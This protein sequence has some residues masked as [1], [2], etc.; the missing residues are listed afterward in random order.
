MPSILVRYF[1]RRWGIQILAGFV[2]FGC[3]LIA[4]EVKG[5]SETIFE[6]HASIRKLIPLLLTT[7]PWNVG[8]IL[9]MTTVLGALMG[10][11]HLSEGSELVASQGLGHGTRGFLKPWGLLSLI[12]IV[13]SIVN[14]HW[15]YP[16]ASRMESRLFYEMVEETALTGGYM[17][18][19]GEEPKPIK[20]NA[21][22]HGSGDG[23]SALLQNQTV[24]WGVSKDDDKLHIIQMGPETVSHLISDTY[25]YKIE[26]VK[27]DRQSVIEQ[28]RLCFRFDD[29]KGKSVGRGAKANEHFMDMSYQ[30]FEVSQPV[31]IKK[32][33]LYVPTT[34]RHLNTG[35]LLRLA[36]SDHKDRIVAGIELFRRLSNPFACCA[37]LLLGIAIGL[38]HPR[39]YRGG[40]L[41]KSIL[42]IVV[43]IIALRVVEGWIENEAISWLGASAL[44]PSLFFVAGWLLL[45]RKMHPT[46]HGRGKVAVLLSEFLKR[47]GFHELLSQLKR[48]ARHILP[49]SIRTVFR[50]RHHGRRENKIITRWTA[51]KWWSNFWGVM[52]IF[53]LFHVFIEFS[54]LLS[55]IAM[56]GGRLWVFVK[57][58]V[59]NLPVALPF[60]L[61]IV[62]LFAWTLT[63]SNAAVSREWTALRAG[64]VSLVR[65]VM[66]SWK[67]WGT[68][69]IATFFV[70]AYLAPRTYA[71]KNRYYWQIKDKNSR[72]EK[73]AAPQAAEEFPTTLFMGNTGVFWYSE[74]SGRWG[75]PLLSPS[76]APSIIHW[77]YAD[78]L[79]QQADWDGT[80]WVQGVDAEALFP[81]S[82]LRK[83]RKVDEIP[84]SDLF[85]WQAWAP[86]PD[87]G[88]RLWGRLLKWLAGPCLF[89][90]A[91]G[92]LFP[93]PR[94]GR[95]LTLGYALVLSL[96]FIWMQTVFDGAAEAGHLPPLW[97]V[98]A[99]ILMLLGFGLVNLHRLRT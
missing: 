94:S 96:A 10:T 62:F 97:G 43:Y 84:T 29:V 98:L 45:Y 66:G 9:P 11:Q 47:V 73:K 42:L 83:Y 12:L 14:A 88:T 4:W 36:G 17:P 50:K 18:K 86:S 54:G 90:A 61:P 7:I 16:W 80:G 60:V 19:P 23:D 26:K 65:W 37:L 15:V 8:M 48:I 82:P 28:M 32:Q 72:P 89:F 68:A 44:L 52:G 30:V 76:K 87:R 27:L 78:S 21:F 51:K 55:Y 34:M 6:Q 58:W 99:P 95:G 40:A 70:G 53:M 75:F 81:A 77:E 38:S 22:F 25:S 2:F 91:L 64:G 35:E 5:I 74:D 39:F 20:G 79:T 59:C 69:I 67:A 46:R 57:Y 13:C 71:A 93:A 24:Y 41:V 33:A 3:L 31:Q 1:M 56:G 92:Y 85:V 49:T 63:F